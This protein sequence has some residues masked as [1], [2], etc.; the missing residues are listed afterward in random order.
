M[1]SEQSTNLPNLSFR[2]S[3]IEFYGKYTAEEL[4]VKQKR[5]QL[6]NGLHIFEN[7]P[8]GFKIIEALKIQDKN[9]TVHADKKEYFTFQ[10][11]FNARDEMRAE[12]RFS[13]LLRK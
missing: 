6:F 10:A 9:G 13:S 11:E 3:L 8:I 7:D 5:M 12:E 4:A 2:E 1:T